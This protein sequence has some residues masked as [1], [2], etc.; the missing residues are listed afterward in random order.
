MPLPAPFLPVLH[1]LHTTLHGQDVLWTI[2]GSTAFALRG[3]PFTPNDI[4][5]QTDAPG[6][7]A[8][9]KLLPEFVAHPVTYSGTE[10]IRSHFG[11][12]QMD[13]IKIEIMGDVEKWVNG[14]W[15]PPP[16]LTQH[17]EYVQFVEMKVPVLSLAYE[18]VAYEEMGRRET[19]VILQQWLQKNG[20]KSY[21]R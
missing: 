10:R 8:I 20:G 16:D 21:D 17:R 6:A 9:E 14:R 4:D 11:Q 2:T 18:C 5:L 12:L 7:Y 1:Q 13:S 3:L 15:Q 19:A